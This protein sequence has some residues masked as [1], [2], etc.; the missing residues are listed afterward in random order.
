V[1]ISSCSLNIGLGLAGFTI[2]ASFSSQSVPL[3]RT[4]SARAG[5]AAASAELALGRRARSNIGDDAANVRGALAA[6]AASEGHAGGRAEALPVQW[7]K[8]LTLDVDGVAEAL[9]PPG[10]RSLRSMMHATAVEVRGAGPCCIPSL[11]LW[12]MFL[13]SCSLFFLLSGAH[14]GSDARLRSSL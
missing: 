13:S 2:P 5:D 8:H 12:F 7:R 3:R 4:A 10:V 9:M 1:L 14:D 6:A 11:A